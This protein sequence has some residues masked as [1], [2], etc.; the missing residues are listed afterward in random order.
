LPQSSPG[1]DVQK[2]LK[3]AAVAGKEI[4]LFFN[5]RQEIFITISEH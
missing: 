2:V 1:E 5:N 3:K 4:A